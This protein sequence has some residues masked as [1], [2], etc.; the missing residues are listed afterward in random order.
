M[1]KDGLSRVGV[2]K[3]KEICKRLGFW[4]H[5]YDK[6]GKPL[7]KKDMVAWLAP[8]L[9][10]ARG[11]RGNGGCGSGGRKRAG[12]GR[13]TKRQRCC[14]LL[15]GRPSSRDTSMSAMSCVHGA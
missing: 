5:E 12:S 14:E 7:A 15:G 9:E 13:G 6:K 3:L 11:S 10:Q 8:A 2:G 1:H 4:S